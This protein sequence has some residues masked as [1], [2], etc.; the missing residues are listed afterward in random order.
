MLVD[1]AIVFVVQVAVVQKIDV[2]VVLNGRVAAALVVL[3][4]V[5]LVDFV[6]NRHGFGSFQVRSESAFRSMSEAIGDQAQHVP[7]R[8]RVND[9][10]AFPRTP[11]QVVGPQHAQTL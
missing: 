6:E 10:L 9:V 8:Q 2:S 5:L 1:V 4:V 3:V 11:N 7:V